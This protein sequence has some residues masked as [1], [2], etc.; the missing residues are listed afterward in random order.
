MDLESNYEIARTAEF[1]HSRNFTRVALQFPDEL[2]KD[3]TLV[4]RALREQLRSLRKCDADQNGGNKDV[5]LFVMADTTFGSCC[6]DEVGALH[7]SAE[8]VIHYGHTCLSPTT[9]LPAF[10][11]FGK[12]SI[13]VAD[14]VENISNYALTNGKRILV[15][16]GLEYSYSIKNV[17]EALVDALRLPESKSELGVHLADVL[18]SVTNPSDDN[19]SS[20]GLGGPA[21]D[22]TED[23][24]FG[25]APGS[26]YSIG[27]L[28][29]TLPDGHRMEDYL[30]FWIGSDNSAFANVV[31]TFNGCDIVRYDATKKCLVTDV[32]QQ[33]RILKRRYFLVEKAKDANIVGIL[34]GT[35]CV[36]GYQHMI[37]QMKELITGSGKKAYTFVMGR[38]NPAK[39]ANFP[40]CN[41]FIYVS[42]AQTALLDSK[43]Y[44]APVITPFEAMLAFNRGSQWTGAYVMEFRDLITSCPVEVNQPEEARFSFLSGGY[45]EDVDL[46]EEENDKEDNEGALALA[47][48]TQKVLRLRDDPKSLIKGTARSGPE[49][50]AS[51]SYQGLDMHCNNS[52]PESYL[53]GRSGRASGYR[54]EKGKHEEK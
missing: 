48:A 30:L 22:C 9:T 8:C 25:M 19:K 31:L 44:L 6:V 49:Y 51:R 7:A 3:S 46:Q 38:P 54:D 20:N 29:W 15:L 14:C 21:G 45:V 36:A 52:L 39:L 18:S 40:E 41:V 1:I 42:C 32:S 12:A 13:S 28:I 16:Y 27:G 11:V 34:V 35:L 5:R 4:V 43:E 47:N 37:H 53:T 23:K 50:F 2:L 10:S 24:T 33:K 17:R 26:S